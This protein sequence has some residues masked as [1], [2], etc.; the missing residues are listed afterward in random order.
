[1]YFF[2][3]WGEKTR[4]GSSSSFFLWP[5]FDWLT[6]N[7]GDEVFRRFNA[8]PLWYSHEYRLRAESG[9]DP[10]AVTRRY[11][12]LWPLVS[13]Q[14][15]GEVRRWRSLELWPR[16]FDEPIERNFAPFWT[17]YQRTVVG[18]ALETEALWGVFR[19]HRK[20]RKERY[21]SLFPLLQY[22]RVGDENPEHHSFSLFKGLFRYEEKK[23]LR[24]WRFL[25]VF[26]FGNENG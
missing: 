26:R 4:Q 6:V 16:K 19:H 13:F 14:K 15:D 2:P 22:R 25:Y 12:K 11:A 23:S 8:L 17:L 10:G 1:M 9:G 21:L 20:G 5:I 24:S 3:I 18:D 7:K